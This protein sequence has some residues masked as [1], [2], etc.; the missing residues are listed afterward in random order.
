MTFPEAPTTPHLSGAD[1][2]REGLAKEYEAA[3]AVVVAARSAG[4]DIDPPQVLGRRVHLGAIGMDAALSLDALL[5]QAS[6]VPDAAEEPDELAARLI[7]RLRE[8]TNGGFLSAEFYGRCPR[9][10]G[11]EHIQLESITSE[12]AFAFARSLVPGKQ[13]FPK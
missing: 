1:P 12:Q 9:C 10:G 4:L 13:H 5:R 2:L 3:N 11:D 6:V 7:R 8:V